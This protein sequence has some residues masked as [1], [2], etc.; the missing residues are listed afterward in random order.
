[1][2]KSLAKLASKTPPREARLPRPRDVVRV[3][4]DK[5]GGRGRISEPAVVIGRRK[6]QTEQGAQLNLD[7]VTANGARQR[8][9]FTPKTVDMTQGSPVMGRIRQDSVFR[10]FLKQG[11]KQMR[12]AA[13]TRNDEEAEL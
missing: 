7:V 12:R 9:P 2:F 6:Q 13:Q 11:E 3:Y 5:G 4:A 8:V 10:D 1:M